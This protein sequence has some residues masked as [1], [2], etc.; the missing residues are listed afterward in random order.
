MMEKCFKTEGK[1]SCIIHYFNF[2]RSTFAQNILAINQAFFV[3]FCSHPQ[4]ATTPS[5]RADAINRYNSLKFLK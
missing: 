3:V 2:D 4:R 5:H 1:C